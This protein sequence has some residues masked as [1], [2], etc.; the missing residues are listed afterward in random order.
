MKAI[1]LQAALIAA[2]NVNINGADALAETSILK[3][4]IAYVRG[5]E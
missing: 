4:L 1:E 2:N 5:I 3:Q